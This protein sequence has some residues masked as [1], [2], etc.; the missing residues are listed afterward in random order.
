MRDPGI[1]GEWQD[2]SKDPDLGEREAG[3]SVVKNND[4]QDRI[5][6]NTPGIVALYNLMPPALGREHLS[7]T[8][9]RP[10]CFLLGTHIEVGGSMLRTGDY[11]GN[12]TCCTAGIGSNCRCFACRGMPQLSR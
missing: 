11:T 10:S 3:R 7:D 8:G 1:P 5:V 9:N 2:Y 4:V 6:E 12:P